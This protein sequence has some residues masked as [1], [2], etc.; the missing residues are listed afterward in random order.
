MIKHGEIEDR[1]AKFSKIFQ[2]LPKG[3]SDRVK[4]IRR[5]FMRFGYEIE[6]LYQAQQFDY[7]VRIYF[8]GT[9]EIEGKK[10]RFYVMEKADS[11]LTDFILRNQ[12]IDEQERLKFC[13]QLFLA[14]VELDGLHIYH[15]DIKPDNIFLF[16]DDTEQSSTWKIG[17]LGLAAHRDYTFDKEG[18][19][20]GPFGWLSPEA[21][22]KFL[23]EKIGLGLDCT[24]DNQSDIFQLGKVYWFIYQKN[25]PIGQIYKSDFTELDTYRNG[26]YNMIHAMLNHS[27]QRRCTISKL[28]GRFKPLVSELGI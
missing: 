15:R 6:A 28:K 9:K 1:I 16:Y 5:K 14:I 12:E 10:F 2:P 11:D 8:N 13:H 17:D 3:K 22:N 20:I 7:I 24:I 23:T 21:M 19:K 27:K 4:D 25:V 26:I 18:E